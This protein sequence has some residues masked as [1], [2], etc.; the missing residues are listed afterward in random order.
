MEKLLTHLRA[1]RR[2][3]PLEGLAPQR[4]L[5][6]LKSWPGLEDLTIGT[7]TPVSLRGMKALEVGCGAG[8]PVLN[9][10]LQEKMDAV[11]VDLSSVQLGLAEENTKPS[12]PASSC[13]LNRLR[14]CS[15]GYSPRGKLELV[16]SDMMELRYPPESFD[17]IVGLY[18]L[19]HL[20]REE[21]TVFLHRAA[22]WLKRE[23]LLMVNFAREEV[24]GEVRTG[25][26]GQEEGWVYFSGWGEKT[27]KVLE[28]AGLEVLER[29]VADGVDGVSGLTYVWV[30]ARKK[31]G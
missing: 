26:L 19:V 12:P 6:R 21:Q 7:A 20:P 2:R 30:I 31:G 24:E 9:L 18:S 3:I 15:D 25:W 13:D 1:K 22:R 27:V 11:G 5:P 8:L 16:E 10:F 23:G 29:E 14:Q 4:S 17:A 28:E